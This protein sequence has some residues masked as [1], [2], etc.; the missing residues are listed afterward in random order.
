MRAK[1]AARKRFEPPEITAA[2][3]MGAASVVT[4]V[5]GSAK[6]SS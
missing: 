4:D 6:V 1:R 5:E 3:Q 2:H